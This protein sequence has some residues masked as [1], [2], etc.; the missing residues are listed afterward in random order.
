MSN[1]FDTWTE[2]GKLL[3]DG[4]ERLCAVDYDPNC[5]MVNVINEYDDL[6]KLENALDDLRSARD[7]IIN[8]YDELETEVTTRLE[9][10]PND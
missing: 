5:E 9:E 3:Q 1:I 6:P 8:E 2:S 10:Q 4:Y 7:K